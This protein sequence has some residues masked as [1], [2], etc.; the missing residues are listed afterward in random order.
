MINNKYVLS[1]III[2]KNEERN[3]SRSIESVLDSTRNIKDTE[4]ILVDSASTDRTVEIAEKYPIKILQLD[5]SVPLSPGAGYY[6]GFLQSVGHYIQFHCA[7]MVLDRNWFQNAIPIFEQDVKIGA[8]FGFTTQEDYETSMAKK[9]FESTKNLN[10]GEVSHYAGDALI[11]R[12][13]LQEIGNFNPFL[14]AGEEGELSY[15]II[16]NGYKLLRIPFPMSHHLGFN[17]ET[18]SGNIKRNIIYTKAQGQILRYSL[19]NKNIF[20]KRL[21]EYKLKIFSFILIILA[22]LSIIE[23]YFFEEMILIYIWLIGNILLFILIIYES[24]NLNKSA[25]LFFTQTLRSPFFFLGFLEPIKDPDIYLKH[26]KI[27]KS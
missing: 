4:I 11:K 5:A 16:E 24:N 1:V 14:R 15:R 19:K 26:F 27:I 3:I 12:D 7:D 8:V 20:E 13:I 10:V 22:L 23:A 25:K 17:I 21:K 2:S 18:F 6:I 9:F